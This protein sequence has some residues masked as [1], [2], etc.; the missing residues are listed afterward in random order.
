ME[1]L[2]LGES[3]VA[4]EVKDA[5]LVL[6]ILEFIQPLISPLL[7]AGVEVLFVESLACDLVDVV[8]KGVGVLDEHGNS[9][10]A[11]MEVPK[12]VVFVE[13]DFPER[14]P[15]LGLLFEIDA[16]G[17]SPRHVDDISWDDGDG[18]GDSIKL[19]S[20]VMEPGELAV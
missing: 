19:W 15:V 1:P 13:V 5:D 17:V 9:V 10:E 14:P 16:W 7:E 18:D 20:R 3:S 2:V 4:R 11:L 6:H 8:V 12:E